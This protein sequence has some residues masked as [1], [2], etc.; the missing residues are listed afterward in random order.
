M[1]VVEFQDNSPYH[2]GTRVRNIPEEAHRA[3]ANDR[4]TQAPQAQRSAT[5]HFSRKI[6][7]GALEI[8][9]RLAARIGYVVVDREI[10][11]Y[12]A[13]DARLSSQAVAQFDERHPGKL[14]EMKNTLK[15][16]DS[17]IWDD[18][19]RYLFSTILTLVELRPT[20][21]VGRGAHLIMPRNWVLSVRIIAS[22][23]T[24]VRRLMANSNLEEKSAR[25][26]LKKMD[27]EQRRFF[28]LAF[29]KQAAPP[30]EFDMIINSDYIRNPTCAA[31]II[32]QAFRKVFAAKL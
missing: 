16:R 8:A 5:I 22:E 2:A 27:G 28:Q 12:I 21:F 11:E 7:S 24:R 32:E 18:Y 6:G 20:I 31:M 15:R 3:L 9:Y 4:P 19:L 30:S 17:I 26:R 25:R 14:I 29:S 23:E 1:P 13:R 10:V